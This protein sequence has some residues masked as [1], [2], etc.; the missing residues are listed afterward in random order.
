MSE[1][2]VKDHYGSGKSIRLRN[3]TYRVGRMSYGDYF[4]E[5]KKDWKLGETDLH[6]KD[7][8]WLERFVTKYKQVN[9]KV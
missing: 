2:Y 9:Y 1:A 5:E 6:S 7:T 3:K 4:L 8:L